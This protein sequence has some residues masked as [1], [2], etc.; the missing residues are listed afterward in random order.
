MAVFKGTAK[1][2]TLDGTELAD[3]FKAAGGDDILNG[4]GGNDVLD[5]G[6]GADTMTGGAGNDTYFVDNIGDKTIETATGGIDTVKASISVTLAANIEKLFLTGAGA[7]DGTG[8]DLANMM[9]GNAAANVLNGLGGNDMLNGGLGADTM[10]GGTG[11]DTYVIDNV[12]DK[13][14]EALGEGVDL[15]KASVTYTIGANI[16]RLTLTGSAAINGTG[17]D[18]A[19]ILLGN[20]ANNVLNGMGGADKIDGGAGADTMNGGA[21]NDVYYVD[22]AGDTIVEASGQG[23]DTVNAGISQILA[24]NVENLLL[25]GSAAVNGT[26][27][28]IAN[29]L[30]GNDAANTLD[31]G[32]GNDTLLGGGG[33]DILI[34]GSGMDSVTGGAGNDTF[35]FSLSDIASRSSSGADTIVDFTTGD[36][37]DISQIDAQVQASGYGLPGDQAFVFIGQ[38]HFHNH[39]GGELRYEVSGGNTYVYGEFNGDT[40]ADFCI[41]LDGVH[42]LTA[43]D[44]IL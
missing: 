30:T 29:V 5:G 15:V 26:G 35:R 18:L 11:N 38:N 20:A 42:T 27:N 24:A 40:N 8:N 25:T 32:G 22:N 6:T 2:E 17:N 34:G 12:G 3:T 28:S 41:K 23:T 21:G 10:N 36:K 19:N 31:G 4:L 9:T 16:E 33:A 7:I 37:I 13:A 43:A 39:T 1:A 14:V 44:F